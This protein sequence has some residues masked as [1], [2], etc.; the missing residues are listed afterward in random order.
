[1]PAMRASTESDPGLEALRD[2]VA[3]RLS[4]EAF[5]RIDAWLAGLPA[6]EA[7]TA[8]AAVEGLDPGAPLQGYSPQ[9]ADDLF[10]PSM[11]PLHLGELLGCGGMARVHAAHDR[12]LDR[13]VALK[14]L[15]PRRPDES[16]ADYLS[17]DLAF[18][19]EAVLLASL[20]H[21][22]IVPVHDLGH[23]GGRPAFT[24][25][26]VEGRA[27]ALAAA[28]PLASLAERIGWLVIIAD[29]VGYAHARGVVH[30]DLTPGNILIA[31]S[32]VLHVLDWGVA[33]RT[34]QGAGVRVGTPGWMAPEQAQGLAAHPTQDVYALGGLLRL[35]LAPLALPNGLAAVI[36][37]CQADDPAAR[38]VDGAAVAEDLRRWLADGITVA[39]EANR[40]EIAWMRLRRSPRV[41]VVL[42][43]LASGV[44]SLSGSWWW[45]GHQSRQQAEARIA[46]LAQGLDLERPEAVATAMSEVRSLRARHPDLVSVAA[47]ETRLATAQDVQQ[48]LDTAQQVRERLQAVLAEARRR[49]PWAGH[50]NEIRTALS[51][52]GLDLDRSEHGTVDDV[53]ASCL[54]LAWRSAHDQGDASTAATAAAVLARRGAHP[55][56]LALGRLLGIVRFAA[57]DPLFCPCEESEI[58]LAHP[59]AAAAALAVFAPDERLTRY[60]RERLR[61]APGDF[62]PLIAAA[63]AALDAGD[64]LG[65][66]RLGLVASGVEPA[67]LLPQQVIAYAA[68]ERRD[69]G[70]VAAAC[71]RGLAIDADNSELIA[72]DAV[73]MA[74]SGATQAAQRRI[75]RLPAGHLR[76]HLSHR[77]GHR[78]ERSVDALVAAGLKIPEAAPDL[79]PLSCEPGHRH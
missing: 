31:S 40:I 45:I 29:A 25:A 19:R 66:E 48:R 62:W 59:P 23:A 24:M 79:G 46:V 28:D 39:Q 15:L 14:V 50:G 11:G 13:A 61:A 38:Y 63:R 54:V 57:H 71:A 4:G 9:P 55:G 6:T 36:A 21:P 34:G 53:Q 7:E 27:F 60:A 78:M 18:R 5:A 37:R 68:L 49:G 30:R 10:R 64:G 58:V 74:W 44:V 8:L 22:A 16:L 56:W 2:Y 26:R 42:G 75:A 52:A 41:R 51:A 69:A 76:F 17:R 12:A 35:A 67:S 20:T 33:E 77:V 1:M 3:G 72:L 73:A 32:G 47:F 65:A 70:G 43:I